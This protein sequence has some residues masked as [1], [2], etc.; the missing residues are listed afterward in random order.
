MKV[1][2]GKL[3]AALDNS[4][5]D[6]AGFFSDP[7]TGMA[8]RLDSTMGG[9]LK[10]SGSF[11]SRTDMINDRLERID[12]QREALALR[13]EKLETRYLRQFNAMDALVANLS[14]TGNFLTQQLD[15]I[16]KIQQ[17]QYSK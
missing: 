3:S 9:Y 11:A 15:S 12:A 13:L 4:F 5:S 17:S 8:S 14:S 1:D 2:A 10:S 6:V 16:A 7:S